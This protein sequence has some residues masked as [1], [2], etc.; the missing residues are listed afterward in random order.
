MPTACGPTRRLHA[1]RS[2]LADRAGRD[3]HICRRTCVETSLPQASA[4]LASTVTVKARW[5][6]SLEV[7]QPGRLDVLESARPTILKFADVLS[8]SATESLHRCRTL[9]AHLVTLNVQRQSPR[10]HNKRDC[11]TAPR[12]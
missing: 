8:A 3:R 2:P 6:R 10:R 4:A 11:I 1:R 7:G 5:S 12:E 9:T